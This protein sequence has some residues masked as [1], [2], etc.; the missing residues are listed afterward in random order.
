[1]KVSNLLEIQ[2]TRG[3]LCIFEEVI[4]SA[5]W[6]SDGTMIVSASRDSTIKVL[7]FRTGL[8]LFTSKTADGG[9]VL[10]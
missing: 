6:N 7:D 1:M 9:I 4:Y 8:P 2:I 3:V 10:F 5:R